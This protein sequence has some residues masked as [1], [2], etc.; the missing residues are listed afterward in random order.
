ME[1][2][3]QGNPQLLQAALDNDLEKFKQILAAT[4]AART[5]HEEGNIFFV[6][7]HSFVDSNFPFSAERREREYQHLLASADPF[8][9]VAQAKIAEY[10]RQKNVEDNYVSAIEHNPE[11]FA[12]VTMLYIDCVVNGVKMKAFV[13]SG[14][15]STIMSEKCAKTCNIYHLIDTR[16]AGTAAGVGTAPI[17]GRVHV[18]DMKIGG[19]FFS[20]SFTIMKSVP[21]GQELDFLLG[22]DNLKRHQAC[23]DLKENVLR[24]GGEVVPFLPE[25]EIPPGFGSDLRQSFDGLRMS[26]DG[27]NNSPTPSNSN[28]A[29]NN[30]N[31][32][33]NASQANSSRGP[34]SAAAS[35][36]NVARSSFPADTI[37]EV[38][39]LT[40]R[41]TEDVIAALEAC[42]G[43]PDLAVQ[44]LMF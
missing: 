30:N 25:S 7:L 1:Q 42:G 27:A 28:V 10:I 33:N 9:P 15:Q 40:G 34:P 36:P 41:S 17:L 18:A 6:C 16:F 29:T 11:A 31:N 20:S 32:N 2:L 43:N 8:D 22:L 13:D 35:N 44:H 37:A 38:R 26:V 19:S 21:G 14:A 3:R 23:I 12:R 4:N 5:Q 24:I 39:A